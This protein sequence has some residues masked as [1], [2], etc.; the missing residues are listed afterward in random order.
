[1]NAYTP[2]GHG[3]RAGVHRFSAG[4]TRA[5]IAVAD[6]EHHD[7]SPDRSRGVRHRHLACG[8]GSECRRNSEH[9]E[10][11]GRAVGSEISG[12]S[13]RNELRS[14]LHGDASDA[15]RELVT[16]PSV[17]RQRSAR[18]ALPQPYTPAGTISSPTFTG[19]R[20]GQSQHTIT[21]AG[22]VS[23][24]TFTG[25]AMGTHAHTLTPA[26]TVSNADVHGNADVGRPALRHD[27]RMEAYGLKVG[28]AC[29]HVSVLY[30]GCR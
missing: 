19:S 7:H 17:H 1:M 20:A 16:A 6:P 22:V 2:A 11:G 23:T 24:P 15:D 12:H 9:H 29:F 14:C 27:V 10:R 3:R 13:R 25:S 21:P 18:H 5:R 30:F 28:L 26:G 4:G 8:D